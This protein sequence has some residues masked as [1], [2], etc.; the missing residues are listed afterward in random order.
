MLQ[1]NILSLTIYIP[2]AKFGR[3]P[4]LLNRHSER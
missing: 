2:F 4:D 3:V 1:Y